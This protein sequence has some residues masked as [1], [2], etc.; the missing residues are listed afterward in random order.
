MHI[1]LF[2]LILTA[3]INV[4]LLFIIYKTRGMYS[5]SVEKKRKGGWEGAAR[6][7]LYCS[8]LQ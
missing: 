2:T 8:A 7:M 4:H 1:E 5:S 6:I 3:A